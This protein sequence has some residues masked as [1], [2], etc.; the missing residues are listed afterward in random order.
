MMNWWRHFFGEQRL[1]GVEQSRI[2]VASIAVLVVILGIIMVSAMP[3]SAAAI[4]Q[5]TATQQSLNDIAGGSNPDSQFVVRDYS[6]LDTGIG[7]DLP[8]SDWLSL[9]F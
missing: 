6:E 1:K 3:K 8:S 5:E 2:I 9:L 4:P 7:A